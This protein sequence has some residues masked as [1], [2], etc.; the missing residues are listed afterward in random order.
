MPDLTIHEKTQMFNEIG[1]VALSLEKELKACSPY[2]LKRFEE[3]TKK[4]AV[5]Y[6]IEENSLDG[7]IEGYTVLYKVNL[8]ER[9]GF[10]KKWGYGSFP[11]KV[12]SKG[13]AMNG[14]LLGGILGAAISFGVGLIDSYT[15]GGTENG[16]LILGY[17]FSS[18][19]GIGSILGLTFFYG[20]KNKN[21]EM[22]T[23]LGYHEVLKFY[24]E[25]GKLF[26]TYSE[27]NYTIV[28]Q[29]N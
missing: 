7:L 1:D 12:D 13:S 26:K 25:S 11:E 27:K 22:E 5:K 23:T 8:E 28:E 24:E 18:A 14:V 29:K 2:Y 19:L 21:K 4:I 9:Q 10:M 15:G 16:L 17:V 6:S 20:A 3:E